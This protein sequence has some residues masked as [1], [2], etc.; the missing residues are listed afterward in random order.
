MKRTILIATALIVLSPLV[1]F[2]QPAADAQPPQGQ[3]CDICG[4]GPGCGGPGPKMQLNLTEEQRGKFKTLREEFRPKFQEAMKSGDKEKV[5]AVHDEF[6]TRTR[7]F[8]SPE[9]VEKIQ[10][11]GMAMQKRWENRCEQM[12]PKLDLTDEQKAK[13]TELRKKHREEMKALREKHQ[14]EM[15][16]ILTP[17]QV[18]K[19]EAWRKE[20]QEQMK[21]CPMGYRGK[22]GRGHWGKGPGK[23]CS[24]MKGMGNGSCGMA[25]DDKTVTPPAK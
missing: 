16:A 7:E 15:K 22:H 24:G 12:G 23:C 21:G 19:W 14:T 2:A 20:K 4:C 6:L 3:K 9:Q 13:M 18:Q 25:P 1:V 11:C 5:K 10:A 17:E 8:L